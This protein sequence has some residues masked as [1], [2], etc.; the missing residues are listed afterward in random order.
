M[1]TVSIVTFHTSTEELRSA[2][3]CLSVPEV[4]RI[5]VIDNGEEDRIREICSGFDKVEYRSSPNLGYGAG[6]NIA[7]REALRANLAPYHLVMNTDVAFDKTIFPH[8]LEVLDAHPKVGLIQPKILSPSGEMLYNCR[9]LPT[10]LDLIVRIL[11]PKTWFKRGR[12]RYLLKH[13][14][15]DQPWNIPY[16][17]GSFM[18]MRLDALR[19]TGLFDER[20]FLYPED[21]DMTRRIHRKYLTLYWPEVS[22]IHAHRAASKKVPRLFCIHSVNSIRYFNK[23]GWFHDPERRLYNS[24]IGKPFSLD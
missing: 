16:L 9:R 11:F 13:L 12:A 21:I 6:H 17:S 19:D 14:D 23:W 15:L 7:M 3:C 4:V 5:W 18:L 10:P 22:I 8:L 20:F 1:L 24:R 2:L